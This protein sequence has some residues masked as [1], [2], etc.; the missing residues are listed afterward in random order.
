MTLFR[1]CIDLHAGK[2]KQIVGGSLSDDGAGLKTNFESI[3]SAGY[4]AALYREAGLR[5]GHVILLGPGNA[6]IA[7]E[8]L[9]AYPEGLQVGGGISIENAADWL[10]AGAS[11]VIVTSW[12]FDEQGRFLPERLEALCSEVGKERLVLDL[13]CRVEGDSWVVTM[14]RWQTRTDLMLSGKTLD[15]LSGKCAEFLVHAADV[16]GKCEGID[17]RLVASLGKHA[18]IP[19]TYAG[20]VN[21]IEDL[22]RVEALSDGKV[23]LTIGSA[24]DIFGGAQVAFEDCVAWNRARISK[25]A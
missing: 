9:S 25:Q 20:G 22:Q 24:L 5:G 21:S 12:L 10:Q 16:E 13:S 23:D 18:S 6:A 8:A 4:Y 3:Y 17:T 7:R 14:N 1:P 19:V 15:E 2:V 11:H